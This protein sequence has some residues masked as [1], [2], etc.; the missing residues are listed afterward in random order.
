MQWDA[1]EHESDESVPGRVVVTRIGDLRQ[2]ESTA[3]LDATGPIDLHPLRIV[4]GG[5]PFAAVVRFPAGWAR[6]GNGSYPV[7]E[8]FYVIEGEL[9]VNAH[10]YRAGDWVCVPADVERY[11]TSS[12]SGALAV[13]RFAG[14]PRWCSGHSG[15]S[16]PVA[17]ENVESLGAAMR[18]GD[19]VTV[20]RDSDGTETFVATDLGGVAKTPCE[21]IGVKS[22]VWAWIQQGQAMVEDRGLFIVTEGGP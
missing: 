3:M 19:R 9:S 8:T 18:P 4:P 16:L 17:H 5:G 6:T 10:Q 22:R 2:W 12:R 11:E 21:V 7:T 15:G 20:Y 14:T 13:A 1:T